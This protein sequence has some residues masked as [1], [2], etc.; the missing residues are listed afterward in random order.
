MDATTL[1]YAK[2]DMGGDNVG[3]VIPRKKQRWPLSG[4]SLT[5][6]HWILC[7]IED[8]FKQLLIKNFCPG[9]DR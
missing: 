7:E 3:L 5:V 9:T 1:P 4:F 8:K 2:M 6:P